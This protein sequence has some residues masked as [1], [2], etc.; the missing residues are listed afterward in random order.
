VCV[1]HFPEA[2][3]PPEFRWL[4][5]GLAIEFRINTPSCLP[6]ISMHFDRSYIGGKM[7]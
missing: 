5:L 7:R 3:T 1:I 6:I 4:G 2:S